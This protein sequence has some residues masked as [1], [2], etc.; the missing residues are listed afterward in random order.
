MALP[1]R[2]F[3]VET[4]VENPVTRPEEKASHIQSDIQDVKIEV[5]AVNARIDRQ[6][7][8]MARGFGWI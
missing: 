1:A 5:R 2:K 6:P 3:A 4:F 7:G 8:L